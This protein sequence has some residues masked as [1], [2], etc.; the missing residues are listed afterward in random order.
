[1][2]GMVVNPFRFGAVSPPDI[3]WS[4]TVMLLSGDGANGTSV[5]ND[6]SFQDR[7]A[8]ANG[9]GVVVSTTPFGQFG[10]GMLVF[11]GSTHRLAYGISD[12][13]SFRGGDFTVEGRFAFAAAGLA[14]LQ[15]L[16]GMWE[17]VSNMRCW[18]L[19]YN[20][21][22]DLLEFHVSTL[23]SDTVTVLTASWSPTADQIYEIRVDRE[24]NDF[25]LY[26]DGVM[27]DF[28]TSASTLFRARTCE[29]RIG[30]DVNG[31]SANIN[32]FNG[33]LEELRITK[34]VARCGDDAGYT[35][36]IAA[37]SRTNGVPF[38]FS[39]PYIMPIKNPDAETNSGS[40]GVPPR[41]WTTVAGTPQNS[42]GT[43]GDG[44]QA[45]EDSLNWFYAGNTA[46]TVH[47]RQDVS[48]PSVAHA[49]VDAGVTR[50]VVGWVQCCVTTDSQRVYVDFLD[51]SD[52]VISSIGPGLTSDGGANVWMP[53]GFN[54]VIPALTRKIRYN[55]QSNRS[56]GTSNDGYGDNISSR[57]EKIPTRAANEGPSSTRWRVITNSLPFSDGFVR[58][59]GL[60]TSRFSIADLEMCDTPGSADQCTGGAASASS[61]YSGVY[62]AANAF[63]ATLTDGWIKGNNASNDTAAAPHWLEYTFAGAVHVNSLKMRSRSSLDAGTASGAPYNFDVEYWDGGAWVVAWSVTTE[64]FW[65][66]NEQRQFDKPL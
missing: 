65:G 58:S 39:Y 52:A 15:S 16:M 46:G 32:F 37:H 26:V 48:I 11:N 3:H 14:A 40:P 17:E 47:M 44:S 30:A 41:H 24:G 63:D 12:H 28:T 10:S 66:Q 51:G 53:K 56:D 33:R 35:P 49:D 54:G 57:I 38:S 61:Q 18:R 21:A 36:M 34:G 25:R 42:T 8:I 19:V 7:G 2:S 20:G 45:F 31:A 27:L 60:T 59:G 55:H 4:K 5:I 9:V 29:F 64:R 13:F 6:E 43:S 62:P 50:L 22:T 23:G 1:M